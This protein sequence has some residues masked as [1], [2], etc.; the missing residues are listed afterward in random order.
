MSVPGQS[1]ATAA[2]LKALP[3]MRSIRANEFKDSKRPRE[4][5]RRA[6]LRSLSSRKK[7]TAILE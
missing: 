2:L 1:A 3:V 4:L 7:R 5:A 6:C